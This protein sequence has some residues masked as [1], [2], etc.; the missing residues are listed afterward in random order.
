MIVLCIVHQDHER[1][2]I[3]VRHSSRFVDGKLVTYGLRHQQWTY[4]YHQYKE[5]LG[6]IIIWTLEKEKLKTKHFSKIIG[7]DE[8]GPSV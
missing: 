2:A 4:T 6:K 5:K 3:V 1:C 7:V 8:P